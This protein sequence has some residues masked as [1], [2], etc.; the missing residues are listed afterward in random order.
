VPKQSRRVRFVDTNVPLYAAL[1][2]EQE[3]S[4]TARAKEIML[5][6]D[7]ALSVQVLQEFYTQAT[8]E[9]RPGRISHE[10]AADLVRAFRRFPVQDITLSLVFAALDTKARFQ[11]SYW[12]AVIIEAARELGCEVVLSEDLNDGQDYGGV[13]VENPFRDC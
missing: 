11:I 10:D 12:D 5:A 13:K 9:S 6:T 1:R 3:Q 7:L 8:R 4:K 2:D